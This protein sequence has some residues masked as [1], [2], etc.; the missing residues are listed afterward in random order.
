MRQGSGG[1]EIGER[2][3][4]HFPG[5]W[6]VTRPREHCGGVSGNYIAPGGFRDISL[7]SDFLTDYIKLC[8]I[9]A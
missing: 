3:L 1:G 4:V 2:M 7:P 8:V 6:E 9:S 5:P